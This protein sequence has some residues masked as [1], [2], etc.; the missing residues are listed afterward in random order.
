MTNTRQLDRLGRL[1]T[2]GLA[3]GIWTYLLGVLV[4]AGL[5]SSN[6]VLVITLGVLAP[7][8]P[9]LAA[10]WRLRRTRDLGSV[11][12]LWLAGEAVMCGVS[13]LLTMSA[14]M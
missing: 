8:L 12:T 4:A 6:L 2:I 9:L 7:N 13:L 11:Q 14:F 5:L 3:V 1:Q 10:W